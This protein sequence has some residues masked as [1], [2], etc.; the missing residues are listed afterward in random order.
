MSH[1]FLI[2]IHAARKSALRAHRSI[3]SN[4]CSLTPQEKQ[5]PAS[6]SLVFLLRLLY[7]TLIEVVFQRFFSFFSKKL[8]NAKNRTVPSVLNSASVLPILLS[9]ECAKIFTQSRHFFSKNFIFLF[10]LLL[11]RFP[12]VLFFPPLFGVRLILFRLLSV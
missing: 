2:H 12:G 5:M 10:T 1:H 11:C 9:D 8:K 4:I 3:T 6:Q 7:Y